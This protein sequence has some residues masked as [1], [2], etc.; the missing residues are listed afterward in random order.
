[1][2][3]ERWCMKPYLSGRRV[4]LIPGTLLGLGFAYYLQE[5][6]IDVLA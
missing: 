1:M 3:I 4:G 5:Q 6:G 2:S